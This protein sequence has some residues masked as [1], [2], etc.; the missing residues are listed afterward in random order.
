MSLARKLLERGRRFAIMGGKRWLGALSVMVLSAACEQGGPNLVPVPVT[1][2]VGD[3]IDGGKVT[4]VSGA[5]CSVVTVAYDPEWQCSAEQIQAARGPYGAVPA[6]GSSAAQ[7]PEAERVALVATD[8]EGLAERRRPALRAQQRQVLDGNHR[9]LLSS[10]CFGRNGTKYYLDGAEVSYCSPYQ[11]TG[12]GG[13]SSSGI[14]G[15]GTAS[16]S[17]PNQNA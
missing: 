10:K 3:D 7:L 17:A 9:A 13:A 6:S 15:I 11:G 12:S 16:P 14:F 2:E 5:K 8:C 4:H 1:P